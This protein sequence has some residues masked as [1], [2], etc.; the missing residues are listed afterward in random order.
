MSTGIAG[1]SRPAAGGARVRDAVSASGVECLRADSSKV[2]RILSWETMSVF[3]NW[4]A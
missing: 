4:C 1:K 2:R 3:W